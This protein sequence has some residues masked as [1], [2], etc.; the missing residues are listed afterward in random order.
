MCQLLGRYDLHWFD[1]LCDECGVIQSPMSMKNILHH[2]FWPGS[3][4][5][6][7]YLFDQEVFQVWEA[8]RRP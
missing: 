3:P 1:L 2:G 5:N 8:F 4:C 6:N 7:N